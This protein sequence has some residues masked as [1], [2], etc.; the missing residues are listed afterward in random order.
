MQFAHTEAVTQTLSL[1][2][3][4]VSDQLW[5]L[6]APVHLIFGLACG[7]SHCRTGVMTLYFTFD[8]QRISPGY[9][10]RQ[11]YAPAA[12]RGK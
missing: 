4:D 9:E 10:V 3:D 11:M 5:S 1:A 12:E 2:A 6:C 7:F 8:Q